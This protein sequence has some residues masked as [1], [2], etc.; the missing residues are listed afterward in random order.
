[1]K[2]SIQISGFL[3]LLICGINT[4]KAQCS[5][6]E[7]ADMKKYKEL[8]VTKDAQ[9]CSQCAWLANLYCIAENGLYQND[10][11]EVEKTIVATK[12]NIQFMGDPICCPELLTKSIQW[13]T[14]KSA[15]GVTSE[16]VGYSKEEKVVDEII[17]IAG[18]VTQMLDNAS[19]SKD[20]GK[21][22]TALKLVMN[23]NAVL[24]DVDPN[25][26]NPIDYSSEEKIMAQYRKQKAEIEKYSPRLY[27]VNQAI[28]NINDQNVDISNSIYSSGTGLLNK[29]G[30]TID[31]LGS[32][33]VIKKEIEG[34]LQSLEKSKEKRLFDFFKSGIKSES[35]VTT[36][37]M[38]D[39]VNRNKG[40]NDL[41]KFQSNNVAE[42]WYPTIKYADFK[43]L[44]PGSKIKNYHQSGFL[45]R[46]GETDYYFSTYKKFLVGLVGKRYSETGSFNSETIARYQE[47]AL[48]L[49]Q[50]HAEKAGVEVF[51]YLLS[52]EKPYELKLVV[53]WTDYTTKFTSLTISINP[54]NEEN[55][56]LNYV[57]VNHSLKNEY[58]KNQISPFQPM[59]EIIL[60][61]K[62]EL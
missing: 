56:T 51:N 5:E 11:S 49:L 20:L 15:T 29:I 47:K 2:S 46:V 14:P 31:V 44:F 38:E 57:V 19:Q 25:T 37:V 18:G 35:L 24:G 50:E 59:V 10:R 3:L 9:A 33:S 4:L 13:G 54:I 17:H 43:K 1:M 53:V 34:M 36:S 12:Q 58:F 32:D 30:S 26:G 21:E 52:N 8:T 61:N 55:L 41:A 23:T 62:K 27:E 16:T 39:F 6:A 45:Y 7:N 48:Q 60:E 22:F 28:M 40:K 42:G